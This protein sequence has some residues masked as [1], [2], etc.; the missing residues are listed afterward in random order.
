M[1]I[2]VCDDSQAQLA[3]LRLYLSERSG[4]QLEEFHSG[5]A[6]LQSI[7]TGS[8]F[9]IVL[10]DIR[11]TDTLGTALAQEL[12]GLLPQ[13]DIVFISAYP[14][15]VT[16]AF[17]LRAAQ[18]F[19]KPLEKERFLRE[20]DHLIAR[21]AQLRACWGVHGRYG[22]QYF[23][24]AQIVYIE[25]YHRHLKI[26]TAESTAD[27]VGK[28]SE[29]QSA[30]A[31]YG[32]ARSHQGYLVG[33]RWVREIGAKEILCTQGSRVPISTRKRTAFLEACARFAEQGCAA[34][35]GWPPAPPPGVRR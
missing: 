9:E 2:A 17:R 24:P 28:L 12:T 30:L 34:D 25:A 7:R 29:A 27:V 10:L 35:T 18:Y 6:L 23:A 31:P 22:M 3:Q 1:K 32:F 19:L 14:Q 15:Y 26:H 21:R 4:F 16:D 20:F 8:R 13:A 33:L 11:L 5:R